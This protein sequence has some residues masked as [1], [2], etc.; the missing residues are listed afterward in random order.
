MNKYTQRDKEI[1]E[2]LKS[3]GLGNYFDQSDA[4]KEVDQ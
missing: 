2:K 3:L 4:S 1:S